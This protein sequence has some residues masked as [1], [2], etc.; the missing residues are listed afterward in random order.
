MLVGLIDNKTQAS[1]LDVDGLL[2]LRT[3]CRQV[4]EVSTDIVL[5][6]DAKERTSKFKAATQ[7]P[8]DP[9]GYGFLAE[10]VRKMMESDK[11]ARGLT[12]EICYQQLFLTRPRTAPSEMNGH[13]LRCSKGSIRLLR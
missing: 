11:L 9:E 3:L 5:Y 7:G 1:E 6:V 2:H 4:G 10:L 12:C 8:I 13:A